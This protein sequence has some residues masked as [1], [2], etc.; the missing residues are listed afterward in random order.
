MWLKPATLKG[1]FVT[2]EPLK[3]SHR[4]GLISAV[5]DGEGWKS[6]LTSTPHPDKMEGYI[7][8]AMEA[9]ATQGD[10]AYAVRSSN[11]QAILGCTRYYNTDAAN[12]RA[13]IG[14]TWYAQSAR[15]T[16]V[17]TECKFLLLKH[18]FEGHQAIAAEFR[19]H[20]FNQVS[21]TAI[22]HLGAKQDG[23]LRSHQIPLDQHSSH[24]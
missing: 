2:L 5:R 19:T 11:T 7:Q 21:R 8:Q 13:L 17:N 16:A 20:L 4:D 14:Y 12:R 18:L 6:W 22:E 15:R 10:I 9:A 3:N 1:K 23:I 24:Y